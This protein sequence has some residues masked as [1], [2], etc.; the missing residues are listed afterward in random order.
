MNR[1]KGLRRPASGLLRTVTRRRTAGDRGSLT[2]ELVVIAPGLLLLVSL[3]VVGGRM[4]V[5][6]NAVQSAAGDAAR[7][8]SLA[9]TGP[10]AQELAEQTARVALAQE[11]LQC[12]ASEVHADTSGFS[13][14]VG[15][16][17]QVTVSVA[18][19]VRLSDIAIPG[20]NGDRLVTAE[21][22]SPLD[23]YRER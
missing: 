2:L 9:R 19:T 21:V 14:P 11:G 17:A 12:S 22:T 3:L 7:S 1:G 15:Q 8:A 16:P 6:H 5:A 13:V 10:A 23:R 20:L 18:C 4:A